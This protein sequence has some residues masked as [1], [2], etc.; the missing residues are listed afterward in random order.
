MADVAVELFHTS[1]EMT[2][3][4]LGGR[5]QMVVYVKLLTFCC[6]IGEDLQQV[7][8]DTVFERLNP[9]LRGFVRALLA[10]EIG[11]WNDTNL[12]GN[13]TDPLEKGRIVEEILVE[14]EDRISG[15]FLL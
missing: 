12:L 2:N 15:L 1:R 3:G 5:F 7:E 4:H 14:C 9:F 8:L 11:P 10:L 6:V 13:N